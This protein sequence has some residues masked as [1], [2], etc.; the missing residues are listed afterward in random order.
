MD[1]VSHQK[2]LLL[3]YEFPPLGGGGGRALAQIAKEM[4]AGGHAIT[5]ITSHLKGLARREKIDGYEVIRIPSFRKYQEKCRVHEM[6]AFIFSSF[7]FG[8]FWA[9]KHRPKSV[10][11]FFTL[12]SAPAALAI[13]K[14]LGIPF[15]VSL[16]GGDVPGFMHQ[17]IGIYHTLTKPLIRYIWSQ[18]SSI[19]ANSE[20]LKNLAL[21]TKQNAQIKI[22]PN[23]VDLNFFSSEKNLTFSDIESRIQKEVSKSSFKILTVGRLSK[24]KDVATLVKAFHLIKK[25]SSLPIELWLVGDGPEKKNLESL[26]TT[27]GLNQDVIFFGW[28]NPHQIKLIY[29]QAHLFVLSSLCEGMANVLL[30]AMA[31]GL[32]I[33][34]SRVTGN[35]DLIE[36]QVNG[37]LFTPENPEELARVILSMT[38]N[39]KIR[40]EM[41]K[42]GLTKVH[43]LSWNKVAKDYL[44]LCT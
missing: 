21:Q 27:L 25:T 6:V 20:G 31:S 40:E 3:N 22:I 42:D 28:L 14:F 7:F 8:L 23:G 13:K 10:I 16:R 30:E 39:K 34:A 15:I 43:H 4:A 32:P 36:D 38:N 44:S 12:P 35:T 1:K 29:R 5:V 24:Q 17:Q 9:Y 19:V 37:Y 18:A 41:A 33:I 26:V 2:I 11:A